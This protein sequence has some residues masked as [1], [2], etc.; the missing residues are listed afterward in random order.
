M[1]YNF[2]PSFPDYSEGYQALSWPD[3]A[4]FTVA[5]A[6]F[7]Y[8]LR[9][10][11]RM[12][13][14]GLF[15]FYGCLSDSR[16]DRY[17]LYVLSII[18][19]I[20]VTSYGAIKLASEGFPSTPHWNDIVA[21]LTFGYFVHDFWATRAEWMKYKLD[22]FHHI[23]GMSGCAL[24]LYVQ[25]AQL[26]AIVPAFL[27]CEGST[28]SLNMMWFMRESGSTDSLMYHAFKLSFATTFFLTRVVWLPF[29]MYYVQSHMT[30]FHEYPL[31][32]LTMYA[33]TALQFY[34]FK[35]IV[36]KFL[37]FFSGKEKGKSKYRKETS[38]GK[39]KK[40][41]NSKFVTNF[42]ML[43]PSCNYRVRLSL[44]LSLSL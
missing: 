25:N 17:D 20:M 38:K 37:G 36:S 6:A 26:F 33:V 43:F 31:F 10:V 41:T 42:L 14:P 19:A 4:K 24:G 16:R 13:L 5:W 28:I 15:N 9:L 30:V 8:V 29:V 44:S 35:G 3:Y 32:A 12:I 2:L 39:K 34:W 18:H 22:V 1:D 11:Q 7:F 23:L 40:N 27:I 21:T